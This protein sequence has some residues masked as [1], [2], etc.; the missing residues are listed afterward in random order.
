M[1]ITIHGT[2]VVQTSSGYISSIFKVV[3]SFLFHVADIYYLIIYCTSGKLNSM[4]VNVDCK[5][6]ELR[7]CTE[8]PNLADHSSEIEGSIRESS[9]I[10]VADS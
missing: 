3:L 2:H 10:P 9:K 5:F 8:M 1:I 7:Y 6:P 4:L